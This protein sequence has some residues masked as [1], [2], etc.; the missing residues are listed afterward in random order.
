MAVTVQEIEAFSRFASSQIDRESADSLSELVAKWE[1]HQR[2]YDETVAAVRQGQAD[3]EAG[4]GKPVE[5]AFAD[6]REQLGLNQ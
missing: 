3:F 6:I 2:D 4:K 5:K 1:A